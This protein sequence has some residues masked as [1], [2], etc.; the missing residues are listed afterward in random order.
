ML[1]SLGRCQVVRVPTC[2]WDG[3][4]SVTYRHWK[5]LGLQQQQRVWPHYCLELVQ[6]LRLSSSFPGIKIERGDSISVGEVTVV[7]SLLSLADPM[8]GLSEPRTT[9]S[10][11]CSFNVKTFT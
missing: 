6:G 11:A 7:T 1:T 10:E 4:F 3:A 8:Y 5:I 2:G 9:R